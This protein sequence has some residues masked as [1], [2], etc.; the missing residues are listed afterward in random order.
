[1]W[2][3]LIEPDGGG[4]PAGWCLIIPS[5]KIRMLHQFHQQINYQKPLF[6][7]PAP[8]DSLFPFL[9][10]RDSPFESSLNPWPPASVVTCLFF[11]TMRSWTHWCCN[12]KIFGLR[13]ERTVQ[14]I[15]GLQAFR[16]NRHAWKTLTICLN[17]L[18]LFL[19]HSSKRTP[20][21]PQDLPNER[22]SFIKLLVLLV[23]LVWR[24]MLEYSYNYLHSKC[25]PTR[26]PPP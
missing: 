15:S 12:A 1:M 24:I 3:S 19:I 7:A 9:G 4:V 6:Q 18:L 11:P 21:Y 25:T 5:T 20:T 10:E 17:L 13:I 16:G 8:S 2:E 22:N 23:L 14:F 26:I